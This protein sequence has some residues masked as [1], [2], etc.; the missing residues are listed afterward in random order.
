LIEDT[1]ML[2]FQT[3]IPIYKQIINHIQDAVAEGRLNQGDQLPTIR[4]LHRKLKVNPNT[5]VRAYRELEHLGVISTEQG[6]G[7]YIA[8]AALAQPAAIASR[9]KSKKKVLKELSLRFAAEARSHGISLPE[10]V[11]H[12][13][14]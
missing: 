3:G 7:C 12:L 10:L 5:V 14:A 6:S 9:S 11:R 4:A 1:W 8:P 13:N 2:E